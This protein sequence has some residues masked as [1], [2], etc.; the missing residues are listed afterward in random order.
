MNYEQ[1][2]DV[3]NKAWQMPE[4]DAKIEL[5]LEAV[6]FA[7]ALG[8]VE[9]AFDIRN[10]LMEAANAW[11]RPEHELV[12][13]AWCL[14]KF[15]ADPKT[16]AQWRHAL[17]WTYKRVLSTLWSFPHI[18]KS[19]IENAL[20]DFKTRLE[21][22][23]QSLGTYH[24]FSLKYA[25]HLGDT[26]LI[27]HHY[28]AW[29]TFKPKDLDCVACWQHLEAQYQIYLGNLELGLEKAEKLLAKRAPSCN[30]VPHVTHAIML[31]PMLKLGQIEE[32][33]V[34]HQVFKKIANDEAFLRVATINLAYLAYSNKV[35]AATKMLEQHVP[36]AFKTL[37][38]E[39]R[40]DALRDTLPLVERFKQHGLKS[41]RLAWNNENPLYQGQ[42]VHDTSKLETAILEEL[43][44]IAVL[45]DQRNQNNKFSSRIGFDQALYEQYNDEH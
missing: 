18:T 41:I 44:R 38:L 36:W 13:F 25:F 42:A 7:D 26:A 11:G 40:F 29:R 17:L 12:A 43:K 6:Q 27:E 9:L 37:D 21:K 2:Q 45:F 24:E 4:G 20:S 22:N 14:A 28:S 8:D 1:V 35:T 16:F 33:W 10:D 32:S 31:E 30:R 5:L 39:R 3:M 15:D 19:Q 23:T 34:H